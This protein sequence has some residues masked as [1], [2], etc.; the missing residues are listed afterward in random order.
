M[1]VRAGYS[2]VFDRIGQGIAL[3]F[4]QFLSFGMSTSLSSPFGSPYETIPGAR[5]VNINTMPPTMPV[6]PPGGFPQTPPLEAGIIT[7][8]I[9]DTIT[10]P[11]SHMVNF[12]VGRELRGGFGVEAGYV[13][14]F[15][16]DLLVRRDLAMP[17]NLVDPASGMDYFTAAQTIINAAKGAGIAPGSPV[18]AYAG[19]A[20]IPYWE[21]LFPDAASGGFSSTAAIARRFN[22]DG[23]DYITSLWLLDQLCIPAC[24]KYGPYAFFAAQYDSLAALSSI[25]RSNYHSMVVTLRKRYAQ[26]VQ[27]D[28]N[29]TLS[30]SKDN[31]SMVER[32]SAFGNFSA[33]GYSGFLL[34]SFEPDLHY[35]TSDFDV[36]HQVN[37][38]WI[39]D[40]PF[41]QGRRYG[42]NASGF[43]NQLI[44]DWSVSG[45]TRWTSGF[46]F[47]VYNCRSCWAT[48]WNLQG[49]AMLNDPNRLPPTGTTKNAVDGRP[50]PFIDPE[51]ALTYFRR[52]LPGEVGIR[53]QL[54]GDGYFTIDTS[55]SKAWRIVGNQRL[56]FRWDVFNLTNTAKF[57]V[58]Q[59][60]NFPDRAGFGRYDGTLAACDGQA[61]R[62]MQFALRYEF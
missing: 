3:Q 54:R 56:R 35:A 10:T 45:L 25:G 31:G 23:P 27:F 44:G 19:L 47:N 22:N 57:D 13:G 15:G 29:Y 49:N 36:R 16:R 52:A 6:A 38:N 53:N 58:G 61:G 12:M 51:D 43:M 55:V 59:L 46:P 33:G 7:S 34:N 24:S 11:S 62:C 17:L 2:K 28:L 14:R 18:S 37:F 9:D 1:V 50:S 8:S 42:G 41:G 60:N 4:D 20:P 32:G 5:F 30:E 39:W 26:G 48:N 40:M 21:N